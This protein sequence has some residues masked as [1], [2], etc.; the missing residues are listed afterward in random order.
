MTSASRR[1]RLEDHDERVEISNIRAV[2]GHS[3]VL[4]GFSDFHDL[5]CRRAS[6]VCAR[7]YTGH[8]STARPTAAA[9]ALPRRDVAEVA[10]PEPPPPPSPPC[11]LRSFN[12]P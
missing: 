12:R 6:R 9:P 11:C 8:A 1:M 5:P 3:S 7:R 2:G 10:A 4:T